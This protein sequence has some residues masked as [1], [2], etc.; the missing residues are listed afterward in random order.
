M[1]SDSHGA[2]CKADEIQHLWLT[3]SDKH[4]WIKVLKNNESE[5]VKNLI[6]IAI[7]VH[8]D[9]KVLTLSANSW[10]SRSFS[11][12][13]THAQLRVMKS[14]VWILHLFLL[15]HPRLNFNIKLQLYIVKC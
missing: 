14:M 5:I 3:Q 10:P 2:A 7:D 11:K 1:H 9:S 15:S 6:E 12:M 8:N 4:P 13:H